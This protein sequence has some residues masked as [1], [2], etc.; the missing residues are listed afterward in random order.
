V[1]TLLCIA[2][3][4]L[5]RKRPGGYRVMMVEISRTFFGASLAFLLSSGIAAADP[6]ADF[7]RGKQI[8][9]IV[10]SAPGGGYDL[11]GRFIAR[12]LGRHIPGNPT[13]V[14][15]NLPGAGGIAAA[16]YLYSIA[17]PDGLTIGIVQNTV[18]L[19][20]LAK[21]SS[22][23]FDVRQFGWLGNA[24]VASSICA[25]SGNAAG[26]AGNDLF[27]KEVVLAG[28]GGSPT[29]VPALLNS[30]AKTRFKVIAGYPS[31][32]SGLL[33]MQNGEVSG[34]CGWGWDGAKVN[35]KDLFDRG[36]A[37]VG[38]DIA[39]QPQPELQAKRVPFIMDLVPQSE[40]KEVLK[41]LLS[42]Q[43]YNRPFAAPPGVPAERLKALQEAFRK[44]LDDP[45]A[46]AEAAKTGVDL[47]Y[48]PPARVVE[49]I[50]MAL[51]APAR[52]QERAVEEMKK[53]GF[54]GF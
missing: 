12:H 28:A 49:L 8:A 54:G 4:A 50:D 20:Q 42:T 24:S 5:A 39:I 22:V 53:A 47:H 44:T 51:G 40:E 30:L 33:A 10:P 41:V 16:N 31:T 21:M 14:V 2:K 52:I 26:L 25:F 29:I 43:V 19:N 15:K 37:R 6:V 45:E 34:I 23:K 36:I 48:L 35:G 18:T 11:Y 9:M 32:A 1:D 17:P 7:Y 13:F 38:L 27:E 46:N 3:F